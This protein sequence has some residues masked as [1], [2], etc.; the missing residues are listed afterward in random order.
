MLITVKYRSIVVRVDRGDDND[1]VGGTRPLFTRNERWK[2]IS[3]IEDMKPL[4]KDPP[5]YFV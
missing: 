4:L 5:E 1:T 3:D 2:N